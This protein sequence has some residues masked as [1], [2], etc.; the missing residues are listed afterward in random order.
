MDALKHIENSLD[1]Q[2]DFKKDLYFLSS[3]F[4]N[5]RFQKAVNIHNKVIA[6]STC[7]PVC[8]NSY[9]YLLETLDVL[10]HSK[11]PTAAEL[12]QI[13]NC[14]SLQVSLCRKDCFIFR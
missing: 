2:E 11:D 1:T 7:Q 3:L 8:N 4:Q 10:D 12:L 13:F 14:S 5:A 9:N 6:N